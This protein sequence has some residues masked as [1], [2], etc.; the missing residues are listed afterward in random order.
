MLVRAGCLLRCD[1]AAAVDRAEA[2]D[3]RGGEQHREADADADDGAAGLGAEVVVVRPAER[4]DRVARFQAGQTRV[5][6]RQGPA[7]GASGALAADRVDLL[8]PA[9]EE[10][11]TSAR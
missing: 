2:V 10:N 1:R 3:R 9:D 4:D 8:R 5:D 11:G 7:G 6:P